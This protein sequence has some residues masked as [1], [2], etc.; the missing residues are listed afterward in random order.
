MRIL[1]VTGIFPPDI[2]GPATYVPLMAKALSKRGHEV[3]VLTTS[4]P[5]DLRNDDSGFP[6]PVV[7]INRRLPLWRRTVAFTRAIVYHGREADVIYANGMHLEAVLA[8][9]FVRKPLVMKIVGDEAWER[10][11]RKGWTQDNFEDFQSKRQK[12]P[13]ELNKRL[14]SWTVRRANKVIVPS[15]YLKRYVTG[16]GVAENRCMVIY[17]AAQ[18]EEQN[19]VSSATQNRPAAEKVTRLITVGRLVPWKH[20]DLI[21]AAISDLAHVSLMVVG[22]GPCREEWEQQAGTFGISGRVS[23]IGSVQKEEMAPLLRQHDIFVLASSY[24]GLP[25]IVLEA[26]A[27]GLA[28]VATAVGG[29]PEILEDGLNGLLIPANDRHTLQQALQRLTEDFELRRAL[30]RGGR[31]T[32]ETKFSPRVMVDKTEVLLREVAKS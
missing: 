10:A 25:H 19:E 26:M 18:F 28:V 24:E 20:V 7:R 16:W 15:E 5:A 14:R 21:L 23:F 22:E 4:E 2:G 17:N 3:Q 1:F 29:T 31:S 12:L 30:A 27:E 8:N 6:F 13:A 9:I 32:V 11:T